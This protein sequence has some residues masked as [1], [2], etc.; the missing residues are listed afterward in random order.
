MLLR[1]YILNQL[2]SSHSHY[3]LVKKVQTPSSKNLNTE[4]FTKPTH[5]VHGMKNVKIA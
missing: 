1:T 3:Q 5:L 2:G 4:L